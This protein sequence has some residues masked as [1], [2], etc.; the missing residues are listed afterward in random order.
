[1]ALAHCIL[2]RYATLDNVQESEK[3]SH[4]LN[5]SGKVGTTW[6]RNKS[7]TKTKKKKIVIIDNSHARRYAAELLSDL[8][9]DYEVTGTVIPGA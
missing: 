5:K 3:A 7:L 8:G 1:M 4:N 2:G 9:Q 6:N